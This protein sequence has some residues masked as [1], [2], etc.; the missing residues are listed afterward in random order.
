MN[1]SSSGNF[2][3]FPNSVI[4]KCDPG[5]NLYGSPMRMC[6]ANGTWSGKAV[7][8]AGRFQQNM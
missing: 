1:G 8:C 3:V 6:Q 7:S 2:T 4:F 5:F